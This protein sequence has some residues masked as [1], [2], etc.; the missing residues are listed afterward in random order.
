M[1]LGVRG[2]Y[3]NGHILYDNIFVKLQILHSNI[4]SNKSNFSM[5][6]TLKR[7]GDSS[8]MNS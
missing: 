7:G 4:F 1:V 5:E 2:M 6:I 3:L 8:I